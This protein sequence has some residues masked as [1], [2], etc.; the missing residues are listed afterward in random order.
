MTPNDLRV[1]TL[2]AE[3]S[4]DKLDFFSSD[5]SSQTL[6]TPNGMS[7]GVGEGLRYLKAYW[8]M[9]LIHM[10]Q[11]FPLERTA[12]LLQEETPFEDL[13]WDIGL[14]PDF[15]TEI[16]GTSRRRA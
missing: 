7:G 16:L 14:V 15:P 9:S 8:T 10:I 6:G 1:E 11:K 2:E 5:W 4:S 3:T 13:C 12:D